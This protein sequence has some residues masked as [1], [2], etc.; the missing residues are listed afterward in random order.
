MDAAIGHCRVCNKDHAHPAD[1]ADPA[2]TA[3]FLRQHGRLPLWPDWRAH[4]PPPTCWWD[5]SSVPARPFVRSS[6]AADGPPLVNLSEVTQV[7]LSALPPAA[8]REVWEALKAAS[9]DLV[10]KLQAGGETVIRCDRLPPAARS[11]VKREVW[12]S[13][14]SED[15]RLYRGLTEDPMLQAMERLFG[16]AVFVEAGRLPK[17]VLRLI[18]R[19]M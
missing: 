12:E 15:L 4:C 9:S 13:I 14:R 5:P 18:G 10:E 19:S 17:A 11:A 3:S 2:W 8:K 7:N 16:A 6:S 1:P